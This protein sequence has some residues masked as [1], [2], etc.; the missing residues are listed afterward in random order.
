M[1]DLGPAGGAPLSFFQAR[2]KVL[3]R[4][5]SI[6]RHGLAHLQHMALHCFPQIGGAG[7]LSQVKHSV[8]AINPEVIS[9]RLSG[10]RTGPGV[11]DLC[12]AVPT[13]QSGKGFS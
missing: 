5:P 2:A 3:Q 9:V 1:Q 8:Q 11:S 4:S 12:E 7:P 10:R 6:G 13:L